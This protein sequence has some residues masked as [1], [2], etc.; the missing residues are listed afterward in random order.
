MF[1]LGQVLPGLPHVASGHSRN[2]KESGEA[3]GVR[4]RVANIVWKGK[5]EVLDGGAH[6]APSL[7]TSESH[8]HPLDSGHDSQHVRMSEPPRGCAQLESACEGGQSNG[9]EV[10]L[11]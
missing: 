5:S 2:F 9:L 10:G 4:E 7:F 8:P 11:I 3:T 6:H 1:L